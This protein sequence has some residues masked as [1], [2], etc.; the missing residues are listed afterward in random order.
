MR[1][2]SHFPVIVEQDKDGFFI[3]KRTR[4]AEP[5]GRFYSRVSAGKER[6]QYPD[7]W[8][9]EGRYASRVQGLPW[10]LIPFIVECTVFEGCR[11]YGNTLEEALEN[12][13]EAILVCR[14]E[15]GE[16]ENETV[17]LGVRDIEIA[18]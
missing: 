11:S 4:G 12:I 5:T 8:V 17:F 13:K 3:P 1:K 9:G 18:V 14:E 7:P 6:Y 16:T 10:G 15:R 2:A